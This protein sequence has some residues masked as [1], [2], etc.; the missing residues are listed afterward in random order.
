MEELIIVITAIIAGMFA[1]YVNVTLGKGGVLG[2]AI[3]VLAGGLIFPPLFGPLGSNMALVAAT[4]SYAGMISKGNA[5][6]IGEMGV[7]GLITGLLFL[8][9]APAYGGV[10]GRLG[11]IGAISCLSYCGYKK[12]AAGLNHRDLSGKQVAKG[13]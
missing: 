10:G 13:K 6:S 5:R 7:I 11:T 8:A 4:A 12:L 2:S 1:Y 3:V 9:A